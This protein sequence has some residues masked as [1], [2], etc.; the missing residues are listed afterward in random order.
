MPG[1]LK[2]FIELA[3]THNRDA[4]HR[5][6]AERSVAN[7]AL[8]LAWTARYATDGE[9]AAIA[10]ESL[11]ASDALDGDGYTNTV[12]AAWALRAMIERD[13]VGEC[14]R[15]LPKVLER[16]A[17]IAQPVSRMDALEIL[18]HAVLPVADARARVIP[19]LASAC[20]TA[21]SWKSPRCLSRSAALVGHYSLDDAELLLAALAEGRY[22]RQALRAIAAGGHDPR[23]FFR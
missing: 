10:R 8:Y 11:A 17:A 3:R 13:L 19:R 16:A 9:V 21:D 18:L 2:P 1:A 6:R 14:L 20:A 12:L 23:V 15:A 22:R 4:L 5:A 7:R